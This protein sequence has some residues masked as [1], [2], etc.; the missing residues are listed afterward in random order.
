MKLKDPR[1]NVGL[2]WAEAKEL[3]EEE[4]KRFDKILVGAGPVSDFYRLLGRAEARTQPD[5]LPPAWMAPQAEV[6]I[7]IKGDIFTAEGTYEVIGLTGLLAASNP[8]SPPPAKFS[9]PPAPEKYRITY[10]GKLKGRTVHGTVSRRLETEAER[11]IGLL[12]EP[13]DPKVLML[14]TD[15]GTEFKV[16]EK[17]GTKAVRFYSIRQQQL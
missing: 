15:E 13:E 5:D 12:S 14:L 4:R 7:K 8:F 17:T 10:T 9:P 1:K 6:T 2:T 11:P 16:M 3:P